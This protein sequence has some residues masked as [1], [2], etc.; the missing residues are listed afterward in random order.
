MAGLP[1]SDSIQ[2]IQLEVTAIN[3]ALAFHYAY[4]SD[5]QD[6]IF[7]PYFVTFIPLKVFVYIA[8]QRLSITFEGSY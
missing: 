6:Y 7:K 2:L 4:E 8:S 3:T 5:A 1:S